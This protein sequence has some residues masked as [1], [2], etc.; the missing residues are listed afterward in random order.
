MISLEKTN[1]IQSH[2]EILQDG[3]VHLVLDL[4][5][6]MKSLLREMLA[7]SE[8]ALWLIQTLLKESLRKQQSLQMARLEDQRRGGRPGERKTKN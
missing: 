8:E 4:G 7:S 5:K 1:K 3:L 2:Q 6:A